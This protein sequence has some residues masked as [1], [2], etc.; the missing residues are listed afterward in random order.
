MLIRISAILL[1]L[2]YFLYSPFSQDNTAHTPKIKPSFKHTLLVPFLEAYIEEAAKYGVRI[3]HNDIKRLE[4]DFYDDLNPGQIGL[5]RTTKF[6]DGSK[7]VQLFI[8][9]LYYDNADY[10]DIEQLMFHELTHA[11]FEADHTETMKDGRPLSIMHP[12]HIKLSQYESNRKKYIDQ[13]F[14]YDIFN[15]IKQEQ[16]KRR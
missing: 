1:I 2:A 15:I 9:K 5:T 7:K 10:F 12:N 3:S 8:R 14:K 6:E 4:M 11:L 13:L 16:T